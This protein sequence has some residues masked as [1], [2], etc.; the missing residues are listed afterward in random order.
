MQRNGFLVLVLYGAV[1][2][3]WLSGTAS[4]VRAQVVGPPG[5]ILGQIPLPGTVQG[6]VAVLGTSIFTGQGSFGAGGQQVVRRDWDGTV[7]PIITGLNSIGGLAARHAYLFVTDNGGE[8]AG[9]LT[10]DTVFAVA[11]PLL[12][13]GPVPAVGQ[14]VAVPGAIPFAQGIAIG[15]DGEP[16]VGD[17]AGSGSGVVLCHRSFFYPPFQALIGAP[18]FDFTAG[19]AFDAAG[20]FLYVGDVNSTTFQGAIYRKDLV[21]NSWSTIVT[22]LSGAFD[23]VVDHRGKLL[24]TGGFTPSFS[25]STIVEVDDRGSG[26]VTVNPFAEGFTFTSGIDVEPISGR[27]YVVDFGVSHITTFTP[28]DRLFGGKAARSRDC[29]SEFSDV[30][31]RL[32]RRGQPTSDSRCR[33]GDS[34]DRDGAANGSCTFAMGVCLN[35]PRGTTCTAPVGGVSSFEILEPGPALPDPNLA[36]LAS[37]VSAALP[38]ASPECFGPVPVS[39]PL[40]STPSGLLPG[41]RKVKVRVRDGNQRAAVDRLVLRCLP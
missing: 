14:E 8:L 22:G 41:K 5:Y 29:W 37:T 18:A 40:Q 6:D 35:V 20:K 10:G 36:Q 21:A 11:N 24:V 13:T 16:C 25:S 17:A 38:L 7:T 33:D 31:P 27:V 34:C 12:A 9:A 30:Q 15:P 32:N 19:L 1:C 23:Q 28:I 26:P 2:A 39:V 4:A 3:A